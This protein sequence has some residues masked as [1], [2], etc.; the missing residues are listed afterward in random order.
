MQITAA[1]GG[2][3]TQIVARCEGLRVPDSP[4]LNETRIARINA[5]R[6]EG[7]EIAGALRV[8][9][10]ADRVLELGAGLGIVGAVTAL[11]RRPEAVLSFE[12]NPALLPHINALYAE[13]GLS[14]RIRVE[15]RVLLAGPDQPQSVTFHVHNSYLGSSLVDSANRQTRPVTVPAADFD[16]TAAQF[17]ATVLLMD[18][19]GGE[20]DLLRQ[21]DLT[22]FRAVVLEFH[23]AVY[24]IAGMKECKA[25]LRKAGFEQV[26]DRSSRTVWTC[27]R[28]AVAAPGGAPD[29]AVEAGA[30]D[31]P[32]PKGGWSTQMVQL[33]G[34]VVIPPD[35]RGF[36]TQSGILT[37]D[38][39]PVPMGDLWRNARPLT[40][41]PRMPEAAPGTLA[42]HWVWGG[43]LAG[44]FGH[45]LVEST[46]RLWGWP[47]V[48]QADGIIFM[49]KGPKL[50]GLSRWQTEFFE[51]AG[52]RGR[53]ILATEPLQVER[54]S[55]PGQGFGLGD[56]VRGT[57]ATRDFFS[58]FGA[59]IAP[60][61]GAKLY[62]SRSKL[63][64][65]KG[66]LIGEHDLEERLAAEGYEIFHPQ[67]HSMT[68]Q[69]ARYKAATQVIAA[70]GSAIH[71]FAMVARPN[72]R[73]AMILRRRSG[74]T[75]QIE[76]HLSNFAGIT[77]VT[78][79]ALRRVWARPDTPRA[80][81][82]L[83]ELDLPRLQV[84]LAQAGFI[85]TGGPVWDALHEDE[86]A[87]RIGPTFRPVAGGTSGF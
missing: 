35:T 4:F 64:D 43:V 40:Q 5:A 60:E 87:A 71:F 86:V 16:T 31:A 2:R 68:E 78:L 8:V 67:K 59:G 79:D 41:A 19:E 18:I 73:L 20:L 27:E 15:N 14:D 29:P 33:S 54:L 3:M 34:A 52:V 70:E 1:A 7:E 26:A 81:L 66:L 77:A 36:V 61:G 23:P 76:Q 13:N 22:R 10:P 80:R 56:I 24:G 74:A 38:G 32:D 65:Q 49:P 51:L 69:V 37:E 48:P 46:G 6:Y 57:Q 58:R 72:Q 50:T 21:I 39:R 62:I 45:F 84:L 30:V 63:S 42:G 28:T 12:A 11:N 75:R 9:T 53:V 44:H 85:P 25:I 47:Q 17:G 83:G 82:G 55:V